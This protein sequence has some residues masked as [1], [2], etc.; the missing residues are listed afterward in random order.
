MISLEF[1]VI[2]GKVAKANNFFK[3]NGG[4]YKES[5]ECISILELQKSNFG[6]Y[7]QLNI[8]IFVQGVFDR[9]YKPDKDLIKSSLGHVNSGE[10][11]SYRE[12]LNFDNPLDDDFRVKKLEELFLNHIIPFTSKTLSKDGILELER[13]G[14]IFLLPAIKEELVKLKT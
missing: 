3:A 13:Q 2:F 5:P 12:V 7:Y 1:K 8:K 9:N 14:K 4:W 6:D 11:Q 10:N